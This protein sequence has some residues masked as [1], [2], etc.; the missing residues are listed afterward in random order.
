MLKVTFKHV[1]G[2]LQ[3][4]ELDKVSSPGHVYVRENIEM[5][6]DEEGTTFYEYDEAYLT[7]DEYVEYLAEQENPMLSAIMQKQNEIQLQIYQIMA[8]MQ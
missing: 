1:R 2:C 6:E 8:S 4:A 3:P 5:V 7:A